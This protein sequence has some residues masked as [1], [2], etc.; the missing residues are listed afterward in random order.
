MGPDWLAGDVDFPCPFTHKP[1]KF[2]T[3]P[4]VPGADVSALNDGLT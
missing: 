2:Q 3:S 4:V 1:H